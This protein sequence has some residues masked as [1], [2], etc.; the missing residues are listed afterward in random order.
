MARF[1]QVTKVVGSD[2]GN[3]S[4]CYVNVAHIQY[5]MPTSP[6]A[7]I[8]FYGDHIYVREDAADIVALCEGRIV[9]AGQ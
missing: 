8:Q 5:V 1:I 4:L 9:E 2:Q 7:V 3:F 6:Y